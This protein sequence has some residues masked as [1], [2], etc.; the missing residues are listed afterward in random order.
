MTPCLSSEGKGRCDSTPDVSYSLHDGQ[1]QN[2]QPSDIHALQQLLG[3]GMCMHFKI[4]YFEHILLS[5]VIR[6]CIV[7]YLL[8][9]I[10]GCKCTNQIKVQIKTNLCQAQ[11][12]SALAT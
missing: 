11:Y 9:Q 7:N 1:H 8:K 6:P 10:N 4:K 3:Q 2:Q 5:T 12:L